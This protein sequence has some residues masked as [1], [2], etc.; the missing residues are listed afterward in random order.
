MGEYIHIEYTG[1][2]DMGGKGVVGSVVSLLGQHEVTAWNWVT[3]CD[4]H[5]LELSLIHI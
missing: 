4:G 1:V 3:Y 5:V 2:G